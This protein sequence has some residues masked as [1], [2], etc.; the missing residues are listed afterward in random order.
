MAGI[1]KAGNINTGEEMHESMRRRKLAKKIRS[2]ALSMK[3]R[4]RNWQKKEK[5]DGQRMYRKGVRQKH[6]KKIRVKMSQKVPQ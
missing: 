2:E 5:K 1:E 4:R 6:E 3:K